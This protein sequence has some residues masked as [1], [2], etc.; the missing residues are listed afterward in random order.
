MNNDILKPY[1]LLLL[2]HYIFEKNYIISKIFP[3]R[4]RYIYNNTSPIILQSFNKLLDKLQIKKQFI[5]FI[6]NRSVSSIKN[7]K[8]ILNA[9]IHL[10]KD[11]KNIIKQYYTSVDNELIDKKIKFTNKYANKSNNG[12]LLYTKNN[13]IKNFFKYHSIFRIP[14]NLYPVYISSNKKEKN[15]FSKKF[16]KYKNYFNLFSLKYDIKDFNKYFTPLDKK[17]IQYA[18]YMKQNYI[19]HPDGHLVELKTLKYKNKTSS[20]ITNELI[21]NEKTFLKI[22]N[23][24][25][26]FHKLNLGQIV[27]P[28]YGNYKNIFSVE[29]TLKSINNNDSIIKKGDIKI[30]NLK[31]QLFHHERQVKFVFQFYLP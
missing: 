11:K 26:C 14:E 10:I 22:L 3:Y 6:H 28:K 21:K 19:P 25:K 9:L 4:K 20:Q 27:I 23:S 13:D 1:I 12:Y 24:Y 16:I 15:I 2:I 29:G 17:T 7:N 30:C 18:I 5:N 8:N 31:F